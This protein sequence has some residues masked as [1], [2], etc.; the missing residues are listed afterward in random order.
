MVDGGP[1]G[2]PD[3]GEALALLILTATRSGTLR[4]ADWGEFDWQ[5]RLWNVPGDK[6]K[7]GRSWVV[8][9]SGP[10]FGVLRAR[11][12]RKKCPEAGPVFAGT[13][14]A[15]RTDLRGPW[16]RAVA[17]AGITGATVHDARRTA[18]TLACDAGVDS[19]VVAHLLQHVGASVL[20][21][22]RR[23]T[24]ATAAA[25]SERMA[26]ALLAPAG[27][28]PS[29]FAGGLPKPEA[30]RPEAE[31]GAVLPFPGAVVVAQ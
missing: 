1:G 13:G 24:P 3:D 11:W 2:P 14:E 27:L 8:P 26:A 17:A 21:V 16:E 23:V 10:A 4:R 30:M 12:E 29:D 18:A 20:D 28:L 7:A 19:A 15:A 31:V 25:A 5:G 22:Y 9:L 6:L